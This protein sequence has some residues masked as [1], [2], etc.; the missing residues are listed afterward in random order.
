MPEENKLKV[1]FNEF[2]VLM[3]RTAYLPL[4]SGLLQAYAQTSPL[5]QQ[6]Y[7]FMPFLFRRDQVEAILS[8]YESPGVAAF[9]VSMWNEQLCLRVAK[10]VKARWPECLII[11]GGPQPPFRAA[12]YFRRHPFIDVAV[13]GEGEGAFRDIL[14]RQVEPQNFE[15]IPGISWREPKTGRC[16]YNEDERPLPQDLDTYPSPYLSGLFDRLVNEPGGG[17]AIPGHHRNQSGL[18]VSLYLLFLG[19]GGVKSQIPFPFSGTYQSRDRMGR[20]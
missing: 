15:G 2:N 4:V 17:V 1:Y 7:E 16:I 19:A 6:H 14:E 9:S 8:Q 3:D 11:F 10:E 20:P 13:R 5:V 18:S 12:N